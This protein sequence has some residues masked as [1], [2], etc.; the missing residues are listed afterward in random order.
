VAK[1]KPR[2]LLRLLLLLPRLLLLPL[3]PLLLLLPRPLR[4]PRLLL[5]LRLPSNRVYANLEPL[6]RLQKN[7][8]SGRF[9]H[10]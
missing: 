4:L 6:R 5:R 10:V 2:L 9:F 3:R 7:R 1:K 8:P